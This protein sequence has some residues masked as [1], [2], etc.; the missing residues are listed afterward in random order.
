MGSIS[1]SL[2]LRGVAD[3]LPP[4][5]KQLRESFIV[6]RASTNRGDRGEMVLCA[7][8]TLFCSLCSVYEFIALKVTICV[9]D[10]VDL[11]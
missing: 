8:D 1:L 2:T 6:S 10:G 3:I 4:L 5:Y 9:D 11:R 7:L